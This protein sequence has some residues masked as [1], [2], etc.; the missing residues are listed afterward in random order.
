MDFHERVR[1]Q[2]LRLADAEP[3]RIVV[4]DGGGN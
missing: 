2:Y 1:H 3:D 4:I